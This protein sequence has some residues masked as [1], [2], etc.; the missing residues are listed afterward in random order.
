MWVRVRSSFGDHGWCVERRDTERHESDSDIID[1][2]GAGALTHCLDFG[3]VG[4]GR[5]HASP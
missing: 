3:Y 2:G 4:L 5:A 1:I